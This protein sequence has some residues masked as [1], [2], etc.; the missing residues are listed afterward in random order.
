MQQEARDFESLKQELDARTREL[1]GE[2]RPPSASPQAEDEV[3]MPA[4]IK[5]LNRPA[6]AEQQ[7][8]AAK[9]EDVYVTLEELERDYIT[10]VLEAK[11]WRVSGPKGAAR[12]LGLNPST[13]RSRMKKLGISRYIS[14]N[15]EI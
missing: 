13:L 2:S 12:L 10:Q 8:S 3:I 7:V 11:N 14:R 9:P 1:T 6:P 15:R 4:E 5:R